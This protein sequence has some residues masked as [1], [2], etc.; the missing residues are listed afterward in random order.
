M[1]ILVGERGCGEG[2]K[3]SLIVC[4]NKDSSWQDIESVR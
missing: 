3:G 2:I 1:V 4:K